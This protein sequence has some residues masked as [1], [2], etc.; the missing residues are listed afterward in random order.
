MV[1]RVP[2]SL[3]HIP[4]FIAV[5]FC[6]RFACHWLAYGESFLCRKLHL[7]EF[8]SISFFA[9]NTKMLYHFEVS[10]GRWRKKTPASLLDY[11]FKCIPTASLTMTWRTMMASVHRGVWWKKWSNNRTELDMEN[12]CEQMPTKQR[13]PK[14]L[15][16]RMQSNAICIFPLKIISVFGVGPFTSSHVVCVE[17]YFLQLKLW[18]NEIFFPFVD[19]SGMVVLIIVIISIIGDDEDDF[20]HS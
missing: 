8:T 1:N 13:I 14:R 4:S 11:N 16:F 20:N 2:P 17:W 18:R 10:D 5:L 15:S 7:R 3:L 19:T 9:L 6:F 12:W